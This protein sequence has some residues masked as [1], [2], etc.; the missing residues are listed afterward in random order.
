MPDYLKFSICKGFRGKKPSKS[1]GLVA[2]V[3]QPILVI[4]GVDYLIRCI[5]VGVLPSPGRLG[6]FSGVPLEFVAI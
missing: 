6:F 5:R 4:I 3:Q 1:F 2:L